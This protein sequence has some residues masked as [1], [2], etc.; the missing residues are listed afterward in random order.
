MTGSFYNMFS[1]HDIRSKHEYRADKWSV[2]HLVPKAE[3]MSLL[4]QGYEPW[5]LAEYFNV[6]EELINRAYYFYCKIEI[7]ENQ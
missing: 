2:L 6:T 4:K 5:D 3:F 7:I 1:E